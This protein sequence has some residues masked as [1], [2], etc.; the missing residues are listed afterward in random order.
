MPEAVA[1]LLFALG[2]V[3]VVGG[4]VRPHRLGNAARPED[5][6][7]RDRLRLGLLRYRRPGLVLGVMAVGLLWHVVSPSQGPGQTIPG[8]VS[9]P[10]RSASAEEDRFGLVYHRA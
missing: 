8:P 3:L 6:R 1:Y 10:P 2:A 7:I 4:I 5:L 9:S